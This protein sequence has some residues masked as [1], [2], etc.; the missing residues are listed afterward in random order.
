MRDF[1]DCFD[2]LLSSVRRLA[3]QELPEDGYKCLLCDARSF[4]PDVHF[5]WCPISK[6]AELLPSL[7]AVAAKQARIAGGNGKQVIAEGV[8]PWPP[9][10]IAMLARALEYQEEPEAC[11]PSEVLFD[12]ATSRGRKIP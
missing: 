4:V 8:H 7:E 9:E 12:L 3:V 6:A 5:P 1:C 10:D 11:M 2:L